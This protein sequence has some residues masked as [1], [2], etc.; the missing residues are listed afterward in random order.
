MT[1]WHGS[2]RK[3]TTELA[4]PVRYTVLP[5]EGGPCLN[6][7]L[8]KTLS[9]TFTGAIHCVACDRLTKKSFNQ[10]YCFP[11]FRKLA[12]CDSCIMSPEKC[13]LAEGTCR[14]PE[15]AE[16]HCQAVS[17]THLTLPTTPYV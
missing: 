15:W 3:M 10:G 13:H 16:T 12:A 5:D 7:L 9:V 11:C 2:L 8:G 17:Y 6:D 14:E 1:D 4:D